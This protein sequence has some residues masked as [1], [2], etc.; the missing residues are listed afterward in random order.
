MS[1][2]IQKFGGSSVA[3]AEKFRACA[4]RVTEA[5]RHGQQPIVVVSAMGDSTDDLIGLAE[6][7]IDMPDKR[8]LDQ[9]LATGEQVSIAMMAM[10]LKSLG[11]PAIS[12]TGQ[13]AC[14]N[15]DDVYGRATILSIDGAKLRQLL[16]DGKVPVVAGFQGV[17][18]AGDITTLGRGGS[19]TTAVALAATLGGRCEIF[20]DVDGVYTAD[21]RI[22]SGARRLETVTYEEML[23]AAA[24]GSQVIHPRAVELAKK[25][26]VRV[27]VLHSHRPGYPPA[28]ETDPTTS[29]A[30]GLPGTWVVSEDEQ[31]EAR[32]VSGVVLK[33]NVA[34]VSLRGVQNRTGVQS[35]IFSPLAAAHLPVDDIIQE[36]DGPGTLNVTFTMEKKEVKEA[37]GIIHQ[38]AHGI[39][40]QAVRIDTGLVTVS[41]VGAGMR[42]SSGV[43]ARLFEALAAAGINVE[44]VTTSEIR[45][46]CVIAEADGQRAVQAIHDAFDLGTDQPKGNAAP[47][48]GDLAAIVAE[49]KMAPAQA[50][51][52]P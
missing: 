32:V 4:G 12:L 24:L 44:N 2:V 49:P 9:L 22:V 25:Y 26:G 16:A 47:S 3:D 35:E 23:E 48:H 29:P 8:E 38:I 31:M 39:G 21:P 15:T 20:K 5:L 13:Q 41:A 14:I 17:T 51:A 33:K 50:N 40:A 1:I 34:R 36:D 28:F 37:S 30:A 52:R 10:T 42:T 27:R 43:A 46:S 7:V 6:T 11:I 19:D 45:I 18:R